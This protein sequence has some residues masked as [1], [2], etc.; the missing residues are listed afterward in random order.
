V[1][2]GAAPHTAHYEVF[3][4]TSADFAAGAGTYLASVSVEHF[5]D[6][7]VHG[8]V[9]GK[10]YYRARAV[11]PGRKGP[12]S[13]PAAATLGQ[14]RDVTPPAAPALRAVALRFD[15]VSLQ[16]EA[17]IDDVAVKGYRL[18]RDGQPLADLPAVYNSWV[19]LRTE[20]DRDYKYSIRAYDDAGNESEW[21]RTKV[22]TRG[23]KAPAP[24]K[25]T[26]A[27]PHAATGNLIVATCGKDQ[28]HA[29]KA[30]A[31]H[32]VADIGDQKEV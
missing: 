14:L 13:P 24:G 7:Q 15:K 11:R 10:Y 29:R 25:S 16:W 19:D 8:A 17:A 9:K 27:P 28:Q 12:F 22:S 31:R 5:L 4:G 30:R 20:A 32:A 1:S 23:F 2:W 21:G 6:R 3:R 26:S 18:F